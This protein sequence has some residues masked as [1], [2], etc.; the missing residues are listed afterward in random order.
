MTDDEIDNK[1]LEQAN[2]MSADE[3]HI[4]SDPKLFAKHIAKLEKEMLKASKEL[5]FE[6][7]AR[8]R[9]EIMRLK[10]FMLQV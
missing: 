8:L 9:D 1:I 5:Q 4:V 6:Q 10:A 7:A 2:A 3:Q